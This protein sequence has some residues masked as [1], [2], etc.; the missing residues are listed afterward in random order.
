MK[1]LYSKGLN[2]LNSEQ[3]S[4]LYPENGKTIDEIIN[5]IESNVNDDSIVV[6]LSETVIKTIWQM[7]KSGKLNSDLLVFE[8]NLP[9]YKQ[10]SFT[11]KTF[12][13]T[14]NNYTKFLFK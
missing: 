9:E 4:I 14:F 2:L 12:L 7:V 8:S 13:E 10:Y 11:A 3:F 1:L 5:Y 6:T